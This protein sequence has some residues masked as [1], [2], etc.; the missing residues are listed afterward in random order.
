MVN[1]DSKRTVKLSS[2][3]HKI[4][5]NFRKRE[6]GLKKLN[7]AHIRKNLDISVDI[8]MQQAGVRFPA[9]ARDLFLFHSVQTGSGTHSPPI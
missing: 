8:A 6:I 1:V 4:L 7:T 2:Y 9:G 5:S 3:I